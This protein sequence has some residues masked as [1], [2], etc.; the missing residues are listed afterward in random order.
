[1]RNDD[2]STAPGSPGPAVVVPMAILYR[3]SSDDLLGR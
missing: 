1:M 2:R 3:D